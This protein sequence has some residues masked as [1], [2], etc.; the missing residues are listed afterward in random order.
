MRNLTFLS[1]ALCALVLSL[2]CCKKNEVA[3]TS[4]VSFKVD[5]LTTFQSTAS[6]GV[7]EPT[8]SLLNITAKGGRS[9]FVINLHMP[10]GL[11]AGTYSFASTSTAGT[12][13]F[14]REDSTQTNVGYYSHVDTKSFGSLVI[15]SVTADSVITGTFSFT[16]KD[17]NSA[18][19]KKLTTGVLTKIKVVN[20]KSISSVG[21]NIFSA[22][23]D[24]DILSS[25]QITG[26][27]NGTNIAIV[28]S[29]GTKSIGLTILSTVTAGTYNMSLGGSYSGQFVPTLYIANSPLF[30][31]SSATS[32][33]T[34]TEHNT[35]TK[36]IKGVFSFKG[37]D[38]LGSNT[39]SYLIT[40]GTFSVRY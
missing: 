2:A 25:T 11:K 30:F 8:N 31:A 36:Q 32:K 6:S 12:S 33:L 38:L 7:W 14:F 18:K 26:V 13:T 9:I 15:S 20:N 16:L 34:I 4:S 22:K 24:G 27:K 23:I 17:P 35:T 10:S 19:I 37:D 21:S 40:E 3:P 5:S 1:A 39:K 28:A 29:D